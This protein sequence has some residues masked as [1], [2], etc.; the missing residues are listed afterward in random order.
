MFLHYYVLILR[1]Y[2]VFI[3]IYSTF[4]SLHLNT[5]CVT[6]YIC[7]A[8]GNFTEYETSTIGFP[9]K[10]TFSIGD[11]KGRRPGWVTIER[12]DVFLV[13]YDEVRCKSSTTPSGKF[14][15][16]VENIVC[17]TDY[18]YTIIFVK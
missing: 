14:Y 2:N 5:T 4:F 11:S 13:L 17:D 8:P 9:N 18:S 16:I 10:L 3:S 15:I 12:K 1:N 7:L 6:V